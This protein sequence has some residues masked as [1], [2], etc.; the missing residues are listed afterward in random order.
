MLGFDYAFNVGQV[1]CLFAAPF[2]AVPVFIRL[3]LY[4]AVLRY[5]PERTLWT[6]LKAMTIVT[7]LWAAIA[8][9]SSSYGGD[10]V[11]RSVPMLF[12]LLGI[13]IVAT[14]RFAGKWILYDNP[15]EQS[16]RRTLIYG[17]GQAGTQLASALLSAGTTNVIGFVDDNPDLHGRDV[18]G[19][20]VY[21]RGHI[22]EL[23]A[24]YGID[25]IILS[26]PSV[27]GAKKLEI[28]SALARLPVN[29]RVLPAISDIASGRYTVNALRDFDI[30]ELIG[31]SAVPPD[32]AL[33]DSAVRGKR[34]LVTGAGG[35]IGSNLARLIDRHGPS[36]LIL[37]D[38]NEYAL[39]HMLHRLREISSDYPRRAVLASVAD[40]AAM[41][42]LFEDSR[43]DLV[44]HAAAYKHVDLVENNVIEGVRNNVLGTRVLIELAYSY[45]VK[46]F[47]LISSDKAVNPTSVMGATKRFSE[48]II[49]KH[50][51]KALEDKTGQVFLTVRFGNVVG[52]SGSVVPLFKEQIEKGG[53]VTVT[54]PNVTRYFMAISEAVELIVQSAGLAK[55]G[56]TFLL[57]MG[58]PVSILELARNMI[59]LAGLTV[60][61]PENPDGDIEIRMIGMRP[62]EKLHEEL[63]YD[64]ATV[65]ATEHPKILMAKRRTDAHLMIDQ[66]MD[67]LIDA[68]ATSSESEIRALLFDL[69]ENF[70][71][72][73]FAAKAADNIAMLPVRL[74]A[75][76]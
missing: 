18:A 40:E 60:K 75:G 39:Y 44:F 15:S 72:T 32:N 41:R 56:E 46:Q 51:E 2:V 25:E 19:L 23:I 57:D 65:W 70:N 69:I 6:I 20:R 61:E 43:I 59:G 62:G 11:P 1:A 17:A 38:N 48:L 21:P 36:E 33:I 14:T 64:Q 30:G 27:P 13:L 54:D 74:G 67:R 55:G 8:F 47:A 71:R 49:R 9:F 42:R 53:P 31:R 16:S 76:R 22:E 45:G 24:N 68:M 34:I 50:A 63:L 12:W 29:V 10:G 66:M 7:L 5:L 26:I 73:Q 58:E 52:S 4:R 35:S 28:G 37:V 3:G